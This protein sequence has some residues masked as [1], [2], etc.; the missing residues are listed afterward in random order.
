MFVLMSQVKLDLI[1]Q[2]WLSIGL[3]GPHSADELQQA[4]ADYS[5]PSKPDEV[6]HPHN[7]LILTRLLGVHPRFL[8]TGSPETIQSLWERLD[9]HAAPVGEDAWALSDI[10]A[11]V[12]T[13][14]AQISDKFIP[15]MLNLQALNGLSFKKGCYPGQEV[16]ARMHYLGKLKRHMRPISFQA[17][18]LPE[19]GTSLFS[20]NTTSG[21]G[22]GHLVNVRPA[23]NGQIQALAVI[24]NKTAEAGDI[25]VG[26]DNGPIANMQPLPY[27]L[28]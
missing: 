23:G 22:A 13:L 25:H 1:S 14:D 2:Q 20:S 7:N 27:S 6:Q 10:L 24:D 16:V 8:L 21:Q 3:S 19:P 11:A 15:Q 9:V 18:T 12:P 17:N 5:L 26:A 28:E 4:L